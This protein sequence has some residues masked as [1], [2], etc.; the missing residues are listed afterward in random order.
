MRLFKTKN[1]Q[2]VEAKDIPD[3]FPEY[4]IL[5]HTWISPKE[6]VTYQDMKT[7]RGDIDNDIFK[8]KG[9]AKV[10]RYCDRAAKDGW[11]WA[12]MDTCCIDKTS[13][14]DTQEAI[15][16]MFRWYQN[17]GICYV[18]L[19]DVDV[20]RAHMHSGSDAYSLD[21][22]DPDEVPGKDNVAD[23]NSFLHKALNPF[24]V[25]SKWFSR[26][27]T[28]QELLAP[29]YLVFVDREWRRIGTRESW[30]TEIKEASRIDAK[31]LMGFSPMDFKACSTATRLSW[32]SRRE[33]TLEEDET[34]SLLGL[35]GISLPL[36][37]GE[38]RW[39]AFNRLQRELINQYNDDSLFAWKSSYRY[40]HFQSEDENT[41]WGILAPSIREF[42]DSSNV[43][44][45]SFYGSSFSMTN[46]GLELNA[47]SWRRTN[48][49]S[50]CYICLSCGV[51]VNRY[52]IIYLK[53]TGGYYERIS[54]N[55]LSDTEKLNNAEWEEEPKES[56]LI[57]ATNYISLPACSSI[58]EL[59]V[60][61][62]I[63]ITGKYCVVFDSSNRGEPMQAL[64]D[65]TSSPWLAKPELFVKPNRLIFINIELLCE[66][67][68]IEFDIVVNVTAAGFPSVGLRKRNEPLRKRLGDPMG[69]AKRTYEALAEYL[70]SAEPN[71]QV[72]PVTAVEE[73]ENMMLGVHLLP[74]PRRS[75][76]P[77]RHVK[78][79]LVR[80]Y[81]VK[82]FAH[83]T[84]QSYTG[85][86]NKKRRRN[87]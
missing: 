49:P 85:S 70:H 23:P 3:P 40:P 68:K 34:Y 31:Y 86:G 37:Y 18:Y 20:S 35:F 9:W 15:N 36:I 24:F 25:K 16:A 57:R 12:W 7:R 67:S 64:D 65:N 42:W 81:V 84:E 38:G 17:A 62:P 26:G 5:S 13:P 82:V 66:S 51:N 73:A 28:L 58:F 71:K 14:A 2:L 54:V 21:H 30:A 60:T 19:D 59:E 77:P 46:R 69:Q 33:T 78:E 27:W 8:Q 56:M 53:Y 52:V 41:G 80:E 76:K 44:A 72:F 75:R 39:R 48:N 45:F 63:K 61:E 43:K 29:H 6:E 4:A 50:V 79:M 47:K 10:Q 32:A 83:T 87:S 74:R 22:L 55:E 1:Y 11:E